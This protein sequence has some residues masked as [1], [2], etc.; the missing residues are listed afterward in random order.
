MRIEALK[1]YR[2]RKPGRY[3]EDLPWD[4]RRRADRWLYRFIS[5]RKARR[6]YVPQWLVPIFVGI[7]KRLALDPPTSAW[8]RSMLAKRGG[9]AVQR[10]YL[11]DGRTGARHPALFASL[12]SAEQRSIRKKR[13]EEERRRER[14]GLPPK[15]TIK[16]NP[17]D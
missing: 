17:L 13:R 4:V 9:Y 15:P 7:A 8:G 1:K 16:W 2:D 6:G 3:F 14:L 5:R 11:R 12:C 10:S